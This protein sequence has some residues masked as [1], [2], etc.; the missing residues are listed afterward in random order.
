MGR[1]TVVKSDPIVKRSWNQEK[2]TLPW[3]WFILLC[4]TLPAK[5]AGQVSLSSLPANPAG[6]TPNL[7][8]KPAGQPCRPSLPVKSENK[9]FLNHIIFKQSRFS[10]CDFNQNGMSSFGDLGRFFETA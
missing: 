2:Y 6:Q 10:K 1:C 7:P 9:Y 8:A 3:P 5:P 4:T